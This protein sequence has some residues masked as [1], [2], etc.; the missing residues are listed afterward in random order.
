MADMSEM[1]QFYGLTKEPFSK[2]VSYSEL[3]QYSQVELL[4]NRLKATIE[5]GTGLL[6]TGRAGTGKTTAVRAFLDTLGANYRVIYLG[7]YQRGT[8]LFARLGMDLGISKNLL[9]AKRMVELVQKVTKESSGGRRLVLVI[10]EAHLLEK[11]TFEDIRLLTN[12][13]MD[14]RS[15]MSLIMIGQRWLRGMLK[16]ESQEALSQRLR[17]RYALEGLCEQETE[18]YVEHRLRLAGCTKRLFSKTV[19]KEIFVASDGIP[20][21]IN[22]ICYE[23]LLEGAQRRVQTVT[24]D[25]ASWVIN[26]RELC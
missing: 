18:K 16:T 3:F 2:D 24:D 21:E 26:Q 13:D 25:I 11:P 14:R 4:M 5:D 8:A 12:A 15:P 1:K 17:L 7:Q 9:G 19:I 23:C 6:V 10:D 22:N 20:R